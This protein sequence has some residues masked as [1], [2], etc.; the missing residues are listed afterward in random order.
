MKIKIFKKTFNED[1]ALFSLVEKSTLFGHHGPI[2]EILLFNPSL[3]SGSA[4]N[5]VRIWNYIQSE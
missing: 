5:T 3:Y 4:D 1:E 2:I